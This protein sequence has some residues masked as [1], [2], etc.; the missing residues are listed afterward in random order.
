MPLGISVMIAFLIA[1]SLFEK[2]G[3]SQVE[4]PSSSPTPYVFTM[5]RPV[6]NWNYTRIFCKEHEAIDM[7]DNEGGLNIYAVADGQVILVSSV[8][9][10]YGNRIE[11]KHE[12]GFISTYS[13]LSR[14]LVKKGQEVIAGS[15]IGLMGKTGDATGVHLHFELIDEGVK[16]N[17]ETYFAD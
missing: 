17:P 15:V 5:I 10:G 6:D 1:I 7:I 16:I 4:I 8:I 12:N 9:N 14:V 13:H 3:S 11:I 2:F